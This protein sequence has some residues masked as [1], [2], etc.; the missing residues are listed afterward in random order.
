MAFADIEHAQRAAH[1]VELRTKK[2]SFPMIAKEVGLSRQRCQQLYE[3]ALVEAPNLK[4]DEMRT[5]EGELLDMAVR[6]LLAIA[7]DPKQSGR[8]RI[9]AWN[10][11]VK[12]SERKSK[13]FGLDAPTKHEVWTLDELDRE[14]RDVTEQLRRAEA[15][16]A[17]GAASG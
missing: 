8:T 13:L 15:A 2:W 12:A 7:M 6:E 4:V 16:E 11:I 10:S 5:E 1:I 14:L 9:E 3:K 17:A